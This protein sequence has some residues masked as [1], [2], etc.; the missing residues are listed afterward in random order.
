[1]LR[2]C[3]SLPVLLSTLLALLLPLASSLTVHIVPHTHDDVGW[4]KTVDQYYYGLYN[5]IQHAAVQYVL[6][7]T[8]AALMR[9]PARRFMYVEQA[10]FQRFW[11]EANEYDR[12]V[13]HHLVSNGQL[14]FVNG[15]WCMHDEAAAHYVDMIDQTTLGH[16]FIV[17]QFG[18]QHVPTIGWQI[19]PFGHSATQASLLSG[20]M[21]FDGLFFGRIDYQV[22]PAHFT[23]ARRFAPHPLHTY[24]IRAAHC[25]LPLCVARTTTSASPTVTW[26]SSG[27]PPPP[28]VPL[29]RCSV[30]PSSRATTAHPTASA[31]TPSTATTSPSRAIPTRQTSTWT[32][33]CKTSSEQPTDRQQAPTGM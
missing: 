12:N 7:S 8:T 19:D 2:L 10:F 14:E 31:S 33:G 16:R 17:E 22:P 15:G 9:N 25:P 13:T 23:A 18:S 1:M 3:P 26:N 11:R 4:L 30:A 28:S 20:V 32:G 27:A 21:G 24:P 29:R 6:K 5:D